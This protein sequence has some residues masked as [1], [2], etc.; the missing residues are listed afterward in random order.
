MR[1]NQPILL[2]LRAMQAA[3]RPAWSNPLKRSLFMFLEKIKENFLR[4][5]LIFLIEQC[6]SSNFRKVKAE[7]PTTLPIF[8]PW[9]EEK[10][11]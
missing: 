5:Y 2:I 7:Y 10:N 11:P 4:T 3:F 6:F 9:L 8:R 1:A